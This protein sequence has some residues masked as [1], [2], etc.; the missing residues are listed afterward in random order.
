MRQRCNADG[1]FQKLTFSQIIRGECKC[2]QVFC[3]IH[4]NYHVCN[5]DHKNNHQ[6]KL[7]KELTLVKKTK[8]ER[9]FYL[10]QKINTDQLGFRFCLN[11]NFFKSITYHQ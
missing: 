9:I 2:G 1:C 11:D 3:K 8:F 7:T 10:Q 4:I 6:K 5:F